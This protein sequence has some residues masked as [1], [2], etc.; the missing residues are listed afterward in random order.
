MPH[1]S[2][3]DIRTAYYNLGNVRASLGQHKE[4][5]AAYQQVSAHSQTPKYTKCMPLYNI[6]LSYVA[7]G[8]QQDAIKAFQEAI[9]SFKARLTKLPD[10]KN[11]KF[12][13]TYYNLGVA[14]SKLEQYPEA[15]EAF[16]QA[17]ALAPDH[18]E[19]HYNL[20]V[21]YYMLDNRQGLVEQQKALLGSKPELAKELAKLLTQ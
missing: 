10:E 16:K 5:I 9:E 17:L 6:G 3:G 8:Q 14:Y 11:P 18:A 2:P 1:D 15:A 12:E 21:V 19:A 7:L 13:M 20:G 4:A